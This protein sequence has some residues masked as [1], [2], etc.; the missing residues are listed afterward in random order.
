MENEPVPPRPARLDPA[1]LWARASLLAVVV[2]F[3]GAAGHVTADGLLPGAAVL[4]LLL[5]LA[6]VVSAALLSRPASTARIVLLVVG[7][8]AVVHEV[9][10]VA[11]GHVGEPARATAQVVHAGTGSLPTVDGRRVGSL[12]D[13]WQTGGATGTGPALPVGDLGDLAEHAPMMVAHLMAAA[14]VGLWL[15]AGERCLW[16][17]V[18]LAADTLARPVLLALALLRPP[19]PFTRPRC[20][21]HTEAPPRRTLTD[22]SRCVVRRGPP[23][24][25]I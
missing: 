6:A 8:Q 15:A 12:Q 11:A 7:A 14:L 1:L 16:T 3:L 17:L 19:A 4:V 22:L 24:L 10:S 20:A 21:V 25:A 5:V 13:A 18:A 9:L 2:V 23:L